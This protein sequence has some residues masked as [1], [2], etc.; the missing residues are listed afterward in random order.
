MAR[1]NRK[2]QLARL[3]NVL[4]D[5]CLAHKRAI[6]LA[7]LTNA[8][9]RYME[10][11]ISPLAFQEISKELESVSGS[12][13]ALKEAITSSSPDEAGKLRI[14]VSLDELGQANQSLSRI[15]DLLVVQHY[16]GLTPLEIKLPE[17]GAHL[18]D[19]CL[20]QALKYIRGNFKISTYGELAEMSRAEVL[21]GRN[22]GEKCVIALE[23][24]LAEKGLE[25][26]KSR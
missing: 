16:A 21:L 24:L 4:A 22:L 3:I 19:K 1:S 25:F 8:Q 18:K 17:P 5:L 20:S 10:I 15:L 14:S 12:L 26:A 7:K 13:G 23:K 6:K 2:K 9:D 11:K